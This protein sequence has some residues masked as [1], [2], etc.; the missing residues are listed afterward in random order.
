MILRNHFDDFN[1][2]KKILSDYFLG[3]AVE[4]CSNG[5]LINGRNYLI[6]AL[7]ANYLNVNAILHF[8]FSFFGKRIYNIYRYNIQK[9]Y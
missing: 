3:I 1:K 7:K 4:L 2:D 8:F 6:S 5:D 9:N